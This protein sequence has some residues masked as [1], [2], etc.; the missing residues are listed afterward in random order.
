MEAGNPADLK[1]KKDKL[2]KDFDKA[3][4]TV[5]GM[6]DF[7]GDAGLREAALGWFRLYEATLEVEYNHI[8][9]LVSISKDKRTAEDKEKL[10][11]LAD[12]L[13]AKEAEIDEKFHQAQL[14]FSKKHNLELKEYAIGQK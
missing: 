8:I 9:E 3:I 12:D 5:G 2:T 6:K 1:T 10:Q 11:K 13:V 7:E 14:A 4:K